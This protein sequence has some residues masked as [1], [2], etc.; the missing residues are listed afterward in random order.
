[1]HNSVDWTK[2]PKN[3]YWWAVD[4]DGK[5][6]WF[7][8]RTLRRLPDFGLQTRSTLHSSNT[9]VSGARAL[10]RG[11]SRRGSICARLSGQNLD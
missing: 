6:H 7:L 5:A 2:A 10:P 9:K 4:E 11:L 3:A 1:M 8:A